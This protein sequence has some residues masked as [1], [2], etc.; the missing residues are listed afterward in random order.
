M[1][2]GRLGPPP[3]IDWFASQ[4]TDAGDALHI[5]INNAGVMAPPLTQDGRGYEIHLRR[6]TWGTSSSP[7]GCGGPLWR[8]GVARVVSVL[9]VGYRRAP[10][11]QDDPSFGPLEVTQ[12]FLPY[13]R[14][15][16]AARVINVS[17]G[18]GQLEGLAPDVPAYS[19][20]KLALD[21]LTIMLAEALRSARI[22]VSCLSPGWV[23]TSMGGPDAPRTVEEGA[24]T[25]VWLTDEAPHELTGKLFRD[26][27]VIPL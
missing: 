6:T 23:R 16:A 17:S 4:L 21:G 8:A 10:V 15:A 7:H 25:V 20:S 1:I 11:D 18:Y 9:S 13:L 12:T 19:L 14:R 3:A 22:A 5:L 24:D 27:A 26:R 2:R